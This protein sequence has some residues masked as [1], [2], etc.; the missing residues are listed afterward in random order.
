MFVRLWEPALKRTQ[1]KECAGVFFSQRTERL[2]ETEEAFP[3][4]CSV[5]TATLSMLL[6]LWPQNPLHVLRHSTHSSL[7][8]LLLLLII[9][10]SSL[11]CLIWMHNLQINN[12]FNA[13][14]LKLEGKTLASYKNTVGKVLSWIFG[15]NFPAV[16]RIRTFNSMFFPPLLFL[17]RILLSLPNLPCLLKTVPCLLLFYY[18]H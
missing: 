17:C 9:Y 14:F 11:P 13:F 7:F 3:L 5:F 12:V 18:N 15:Q 8:C 10:K 2:V 16:L 1:N 4:I 6:F